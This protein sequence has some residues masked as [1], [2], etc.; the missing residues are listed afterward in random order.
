[1]K[2]TMASNQVCRLFLL[3]WGLAALC[4]CAAARPGGGAGQ[5]LEPG[6]YVQQV[7]RSPALQPAALDY[8]VAPLPVA[9]AQGIST[10]EA[11]AVFQEELVQALQANG[12]RVNGGSPDA[13]LSGQVAR[14]TVAA[15]V[16]RFLS[17]RGQAEVQAG[18]EIRRG[19]EVLFAFQDR[20][21]VNPLVNPRRQ[22]A[23]EPNLLAR[24]AARRLA[25]NLV[26]ELLLPPRQAADDVNLPGPQSPG[27]RPQE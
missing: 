21:K 9:F 25:M 12:L 8:T 16:W 1:M 23:L 13:V 11:A 6:R 5:S 26:N 15:P 17:G 18:G 19:Q 4:A 22:P 27:A 2:K 10:Q 3:A 24:Q 14:F 7:Y 20:V